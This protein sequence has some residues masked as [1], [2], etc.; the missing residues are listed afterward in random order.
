METTVGS[1]V[2]IGML[3]SNYTM[4]PPTK[5]DWKCAYAIA[6]PCQPVWGSR[7]DSIFGPAD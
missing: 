5:D 6:I 3:D 2:P 7:L 4:P 1:V